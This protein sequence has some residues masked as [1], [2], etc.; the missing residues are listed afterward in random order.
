MLNEIITKALKREY[1]EI[2]T[3]GFNFWYLTIGFETENE[4]EFEEMQA[5]Y[6]KTIETLKSL[7]FRIQYYDRIENS[8]TFKNGEFIVNIED[9]TINPYDL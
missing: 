3:S 5:A 2:E 8:Y 1:V 9:G 4:T 7:G 6:K